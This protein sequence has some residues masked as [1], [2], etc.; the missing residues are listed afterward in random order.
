MQIID[1]SMTI[2][3]MWRWPDTLEVIKDFERGDLIRSTAIRIG[4]HAFTHV[5]APLHIEAG[6]ENMDC[7]VLE[8]VCGPAA[9]MDLR[10]IQPNQEI[11]PDI[12]EKQAGHMR[13]GDILLLQTAWDTQRD[14]TSHEYWQE[15]PF[16]NRDAAAWL[17]NLPIKAVGFDFPQDYAI[18]EIPERRPDVTELPTHDLVLR[19]GIH[20]IEY[21][22]G[23][24]QI[25][26]GRVELFALPLKVAGAEGACARVVAR[27]P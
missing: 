18:R 7:L 23:L 27:V 1:L 17:A 20:L 11:T 21:L 25:T 3:P 14:C 5:D 24:S 10:P 4:M 13:D 26:V 19:K 9:V 6:R 12:L 2:Q 8:N 15:A 16:L 22:C